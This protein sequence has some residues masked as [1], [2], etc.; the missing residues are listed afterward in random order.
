[1]GFKKNR[2]LPLGE[3]L[4]ESYL[5]PIIGV[6]HFVTY[7]CLV[8]LFKIF[9]TSPNQPIGK[10]TSIYIILFSN[11]GKLPTIKMF[12]KNYVFEFPEN[13]KRILHIL[14]LHSSILAIWLENCF[15]KSVFI[16]KINNFP[17]KNHHQNYE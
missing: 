1:M 14:S 5:N 7:V 10:Y 17:R 3:Y 15:E 13:K 12:P 4:C 16:V 6:I 9:Y 2:K 8:I 11:L